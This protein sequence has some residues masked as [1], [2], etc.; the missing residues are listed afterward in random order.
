MK[1]IL[2]SI[3]LFA[4]VAGAAVLPRA[5]SHGEVVS[6]KEAQ[7]YVVDNVSLANVSAKSYVIFD[8]ETGEI[9]L[10]K[11][12]EEV[13]P[14]A[15]VTKL[16]TAAA[17]LDS[18]IIDTEILVTNEDVAAEG[19]AGKLEAGHMYQLRELLF[20]LLLESSNDAA[21]AMQRLLP[22]KEWFNVKLKDASGLS[23]ENTAS[24]RN[25]AD[26]IGKLYREKKYLFDI[27]KLPQYVGE[28]TGWVNNSPIRDL[29]G[30]LGGKHGYTVAA[31]RTLVAFFSEKSLNG[32]EL[33]Y[34][35]LGS[36][37]I[38]ED[39][40]NLRETVANSVHLE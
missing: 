14:I 12:A 8:A 7:A 40:L 28:E 35:L 17:L 38:R 25:L 9:L 18:E 22:K 6:S 26:E 20:P 4:A 29:E 11:N 23:D 21:E 30:Y 32:R 37:N 33:G 24:A 39:T 16:F 31:N 27:T 13:L 34:V 5:D 10:S 15:S 19:R 1:L 2:V 3:F 36:D